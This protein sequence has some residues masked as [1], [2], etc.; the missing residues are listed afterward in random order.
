M[1]ERNLVKYLIIA[2]LCVIFIFII[3]HVA[4]TSL[5]RTSDKSLEKSLNSFS[6]CDSTDNTCGNNMYHCLGGNAIRGCRNQKDGPFPMIDCSSQCFKGASPPPPTDP[7]V[8]IKCNVNSSCNNGKCVCNSGWSG[9]NCDQP[10]TIPFC[11]KPPPCSPNY[12]YCL[13]GKGQNGCSKGE[14]NS[15]DCTSQCIYKSCIPNCNGNACGG[16]DGCG[17]TCKTGT[18]NTPG[19]ICQNGVCRQPQCIPNCST[20]KCGDDDGCG[21]TCTNCDNG[22]T[23]SNSN[24]IPPTIGY[25]LNYNLSRIKIKPDPIPDNNYFILLGDWGGVSANAN[26]GS[27]QLAVAK[28]MKDYYN[29]QKT[30]EDKLKTLLFVATLGD[31]FYY[32]GH[33]GTQKMWDSTWKNVYGTDLTNVPWFAVMGNH[34]FGNNDPWSICPEKNPDKSQVTIVNKTAYNC[35]QLDNDKQTTKKPRPVGT[36]NYVM[37]DFCYHYEIPELNF[38]LIA[39]S[40][41]S[42]DSPGGIGGD[43]TNSWCGDHEC[44]AYQTSLNC[45]GPQPMTDKLQ[46]IYNAGQDLLIERAKNSENT[47]ILITNHY[48]D[49]ED[50]LRNTFISNTSETKKA[51]QTV[52]TAGGH[53]H[54]THCITQPEGELCLS[55]VSGGGGGC[56]STTGPTTDVSGFYVVHFYK[57]SSDNT[58]K[59]KTEKILYP[60]SSV[61]PPAYHKNG[62]RIVNVP[63]SPDSH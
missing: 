14:W 8:D 44:G 55:I 24:C 37:P 47:N 36:Y 42:T 28:M 29:A 34:D 58:I 40:C 18:C 2:L 3:I 23:C 12:Y 9:A 60:Y 45:G 26:L 32:T 41:D 43:G 27:S 5:H 53:I 17:G 54:N 15:N 21:G 56:C 51:K 4:R 38:E 63:H 61:K 39:L 35:N 59:M 25:Q 30:G 33:D 48:P 10:G 57:D 16:E 11:D 50:K 62:P 20:K 49:V 13:T 1:S 22:Y 7:C 52:I 19:D 46:Q 6:P 31:N